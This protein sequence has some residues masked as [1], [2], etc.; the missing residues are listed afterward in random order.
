VQKAVVRGRA[1]KGK[2]QPAPALRAEHG[3]RVKVVAQGKQPPAAG[4]KVVVK[5]ASPKV[6]V[7]GR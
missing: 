6:K 2:A 4:K 3:K 5:T 7:A 1:H